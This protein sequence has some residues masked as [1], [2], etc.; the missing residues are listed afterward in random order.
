[1]MKKKNSIHFYNEK[2]V[3]LKISQENKSLIAQKKDVPHWL[4]ETNSNEIYK[5][6]TM[7][8]QNR[9]FQKLSKI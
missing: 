5:Q 9:I 8:I 4:H 3:F 2:Q 6:Q 1:M 7:D